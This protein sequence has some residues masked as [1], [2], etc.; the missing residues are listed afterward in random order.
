ME[1]LR[2]L[3]LFGGVSEE[4]EVSLVSASS[5]L[6]HIDRAKYDITSVGITKEGKWLLYEGSAESLAKNG[7]LSPTAKEVI[8]TMGGIL[9][10]DGEKR[11]KKEIDVVFPV[12][13]GNNC[14]DG[15]LQGLLAFY[16]MKFVG[17]G[18]AASAI[19]MDKAETKRYLAPH[20]IPQ[21]RAI[22]VERADF[23]E[24][25]EE[26]QKSIAESIGYPAF[27]KPS[28][29]GSSCGVSRLENEDGL[30]AALEK[31]FLYDTRVL[32]EEFIK[33]AEVEVAVL[34]NGEKLTVSTP[35]EIAPNSTFYDYDT[36][37]K[38]DV[39]KYY[40][41][42]RI[43]DAS[44]ERVKILAATIYSILGCRG[45]SRVDFFVDESGRVIFNEINTMPGFTSISMYPKMMA[46]DG[47]PFAELIDRLITLALES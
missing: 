33:G 39:A 38:S 37:Y 21:A 24:R 3:C 14:E 10:L 7:F 17:C 47:I 30:L 19:G 4:H 18:I 5:V 35:G 6:S 43:S 12:M 8:P 46:H 16:G 9:L 40:I 13:H 41:P 26:Y 29:S 20:G 27:V 36:K 23:R 28:S 32:V 31:A 2:V 45:L 44:R 25:L 42:A 1:K 11:A 22:V 15:K 34:G